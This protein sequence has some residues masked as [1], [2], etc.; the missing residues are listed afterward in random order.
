M[1]IIAA[2]DTQVVVRPENIF[3]TVKAMTSRETET[4]APEW[5]SYTNFSKHGS[6]NDTNEGGEN[7][8][9]PL[10]TVK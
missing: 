9:G 8:E 5:W 7:T 1:T 3:M 10:T 6:N 4:Q 2:I